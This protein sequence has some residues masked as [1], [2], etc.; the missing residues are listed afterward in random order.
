MV[1]AIPGVT[2]TEGWL[3]KIHLDSFIL[4]GGSELRVT[5]IENYLQ[6]ILSYLM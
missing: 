6:G 3:E 4:W 1:L 2:S 5:W